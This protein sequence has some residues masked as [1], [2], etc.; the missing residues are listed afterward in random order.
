MH[1][2]QKYIFATHQAMVLHFAV[3]KC[4]A[5]CWHPGKEKGAQLLQMDFCIKYIF[6]LGEREVENSR[7]PSCLNILFTNYRRNVITFFAIRC[8]KNLELQNFVFYMIV[9]FWKKFKIKKVIDTVS[10]FFILLK[11]PASLLQPLFL[12][13]KWQKK[14]KILA[15]CA[16]LFLFLPFLCPYRS[17]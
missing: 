2:M 14:N 3:Q 15:I 4:S 1:L 5:K 13:R 11:T 10:L 16:C 12:L 6:A 9:S 7:A 17:R 8:K